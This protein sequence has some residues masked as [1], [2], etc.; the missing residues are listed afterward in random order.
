MSAIAEKRV[1]GIIKNS[2]LLLNS[3]YFDGVD[4]AKKDILI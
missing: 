2:G 3:G 4:L 1:L